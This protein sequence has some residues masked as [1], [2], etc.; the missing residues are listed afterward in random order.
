M[1]HM[2][3]LGRYIFDNDNK[4]SVFLKKT[5]PTLLILGHCYKLNNS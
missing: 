2:D 3:G 1:I 4:V 5:S